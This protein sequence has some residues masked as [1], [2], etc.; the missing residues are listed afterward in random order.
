M[1]RENRLKFSDVLPTLCVYGGKRK[2]K[3]QVSACSQTERQ[4]NHRKLRPS[5]VQFRPVLLIG[6]DQTGV[7]ILPVE[8][9]PDM[10]RHTLSEKLGSAC[11]GF[12]FYKCSIDI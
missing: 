9:P 11:N 7:R 4:L 2:Q 5:N 8:F 6:K 3:P 12:G 10:K 1:Y